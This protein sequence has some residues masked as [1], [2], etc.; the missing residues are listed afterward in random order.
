MTKHRLTGCDQRKEEQLG[1]YSVDDCSLELRFSLPAREYG[2]FP[3]V[4]AGL[5]LKARK[6]GELE[7]CA[8][9]WS[10]YVHQERWRVTFTSGGPS[11]P[12]D[13]CI[14]GLFWTLGASCQTSFNAN[15]YVTQR[16]WAFWADISNGAVQAIFT[17]SAGG[18]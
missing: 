2:V 4:A 17:T 14:P 10:K 1:P 3:H 7:R 15:R 18:R 12:I 5:L 9:G 8:I 16:V 13:R 6:G 11:I